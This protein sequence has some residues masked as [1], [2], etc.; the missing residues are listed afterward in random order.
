[1]A[2]K[3]SGGS[4][5]KGRENRLKKASE[6]VESRSICLQRK[7]WNKLEKEAEG[8]TATRYA[9]K[10][11]QC[12]FTEE[13]VHKVAFVY[14]VEEYILLAVLFGTESQISEYWSANFDVNA[15]LYTFEPTENFSD[16]KVIRIGKE[17]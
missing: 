15:T 9:A 8:E 3:Q 16:V 2:G 11:L 4:S 14:D 13:N 12:H 5:A 6:L 17:E 1:M 7:Y 10:L